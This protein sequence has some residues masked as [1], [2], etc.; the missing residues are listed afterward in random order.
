[1]SEPYVV[2]TSAACVCITSFLYACIKL[3][4]YV[5]VEK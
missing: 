5:N 1:M 3:Y 4:V 2:K